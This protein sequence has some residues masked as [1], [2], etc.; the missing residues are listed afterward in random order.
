MRE[1]V[2]DKPGARGS[3]GKV[4]LAAILLEVSNQ[5]AASRNL[6]DALAILAQFAAKE[7]GADRGSVFL[8]DPK[9][10]E[11]YTRF[12]DGRFNREI[13]ILNSSGVAGHVFKTGK[14][15]IIHDAYAD[16]RFQKEIDLQTGY[17]T[18]SILCVP[19]RTLKGDLIGVAQ[20]LN[21]RGGRFSERDL[22]LLEAMVAQ[23]AVALEGHRTVEHLK[24]ARLQE[25]EFLDVVSEVSSEIKL[26][27]L[28]QKLI[29]AITKMLDAERSTLFINDE[30]ANELYTE[31]GE[32]LGATQIRMPNNI[33]IAGTVFQSGE[34]VNIPHAYADLRFNPAFDRKTGFFTRSILC[35][36]VVN[37][38]GKKIG[39]TQVL[40]KRGG[41]F[42]AE[43]E[44]RLKA[45]T[46]QISIGLENAK[47]FDDVENIKNYNES[48]LESMSSG[49]ITLNPDGLIVTCNSA[50]LRI[51][52][53]QPAEI[54]DHPA[55]DFLVGP[56]AWMME[57]IKH[58]EESQQGD[59]IMDAE[60]TFSG[61]R[62][63]VNVTVLPLISVNRKKLGLM[64]MIEDITSEKRMKSTMARY[65]DPSLADKLLEAGE[66]LLGGQSSIATIL[67]S[68]IRS[69]TTLTEELGAQATV[70]LLNEY[71]TVMVDCIQ[72]Q[73]GMLDKFIGDAI[74]AVFGIPLAHPDDEDRAV[75][76]AIAMLTELGAFN[77]LRVEEGRKPINIGIGLNTDTIVSG[78]IGSPKRMDY[79]VIGDG[80]NLAARL[81]SA[82]KK[83][84]ARILASELT[85]K[86]LKGTYRS[87]EVDRVVVKGKTQP[88]GIF[89]IVDYHTDESFPNLMGVLNAFKFG[90]KC[91]REA[92]WDDAI[93][94]FN[95]ALSLNPED[96]TSKM[97]VERC[98]IL[99]KSPPAPDWN[100]VW[101]MDSK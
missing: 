47:L 41:A 89:E 55:A 72:S 54:L 69:F 37:K 40:N 85:M 15:V 6:E 27:P 22:S 95:E 28:L 65:M 53:I 1:L 79:T 78:N 97:Y 92:R 77:R 19:L 12:D 96:Y 17:K 75:R 81:E 34:T 31:V 43:D 83:Y 68:D 71:F 29:R 10:G 16:E 56:N 42:T 33:G 62:L 93:M 51:M 30:K 57:R 21:K 52:K 7:S 91:Y 88:V 3:P 74:M 84:G 44:A 18:E 99:R 86:K 26:G 64:L 50:A 23:A 46:S 63:S 13:R 59:V 4:R 9:S 8:N 45:F 101:V 25:L 87:R 94:A 90:L 61:E 24:A 35:V 76:A 82:C 14:G 80:V 58:V 32:G 2:K 20:V 48:I 36:P 100:G 49:V 38:N 60:A 73:G 67:F 66:D 98:E 39:V 70:S 11:L 5:L